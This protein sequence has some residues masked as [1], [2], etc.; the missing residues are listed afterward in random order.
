MRESD[1]PEVLELMKVSLGEPPGLDRTQDLFRWKHEQNPF[2]RSVGLVADSGSGIVGLRTFMRWKLITPDSRVL[3]AVRAVDTATHPHFQRQGIFRRLTEEALEVAR[4]ESVDLVFNTP[5]EKSKPGYLKLGWKEVGPIGAM[6]RPKLRAI[7]KRPVERGATAEISALIDGGAPVDAQF[8]ESRPASGTRTARGADY[9][10]W[11]FDH[12]GVEYRAVSNETSVAVV[13]A[14]RRRGRDELV[15][16]D[17]FGDPGRA[18]KRVV[19][20]SH[21]DYVATWFSKGSP[22]RRAAIRRG[23]MPVPGVRALTLVMRPLSP[24][25]EELWSIDAWDMAVSDFELL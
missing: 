20:S 17:V 23:I 2:G 5:N 11:R 16:A 14:N 3:H 10:Q 19:E 24:V 13:R 15:V 22:E 12:P 4:S 7:G 8:L 18:F 1:L 6:V 21:A 25:P 9:L